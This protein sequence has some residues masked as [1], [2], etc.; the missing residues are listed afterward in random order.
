MVVCASNDGVAVLPPNPAP[1]ACWRR[2][3]PA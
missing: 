2:R 1:L 3:T